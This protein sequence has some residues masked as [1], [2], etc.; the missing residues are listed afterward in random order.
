[1][2]ILLFSDFDICRFYFPPGSPYSSSLYCVPL[3]GFMVSAG[4]K[5][6]SYC[7]LFR[8]CKG[9]ICFTN[10][11]SFCSRNTIKNLFMHIVQGHLSELSVPNQYSFVRSVRPKDTGFQKGKLSRKVH[12]KPFC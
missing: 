5:I 2:V 6:Q 1:M 7:P 8:L 12:K 9:R 11:K 10:H 3:L 4:F